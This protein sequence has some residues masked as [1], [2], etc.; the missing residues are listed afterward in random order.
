MEYRRIGLSG[1]KVSTIS[2][3]SW[4]TYGTVTE[5]EAA[6]TC[7][8]RAYDL[9]VNHFDCADAYGDKPGDAEQFLGEALADFPRSSYVLAT[10]CYWPVGPG[11]NDRG[12]SRKHIFESVDN[13]LRRLRTDY[14]DVFY[15]HRYDEE[16]P[17]D[18]TLRAL[19]DLIRQGKVLYAGV[20]EWSATQLAAAAERARRWHL[21]PIIVNQPEY[22]IL[23]RRI[24]EEVLPVCE[25]E[26]IGTIVWSPLAQGLLTGKYRP[27]QSPPEGSRGA[28]PRV[29][30]PMRGWL[31]EE[32]MQVVERLRP[33]A[34]EAG[35]PLA[36]MALAWCLRSPLV[37]SALTGATRPAQVEENVRAAD[38]VLGPDVLQAIDA[39]LA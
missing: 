10:K 19:D 39:A 27:G 9:G 12:L 3:G 17:L 28:H 22:N 29:G 14:I 1:L 36:Q 34:R 15:C 20:S 23:Q 6:R 25:R 35:L 13:S 37:A 30:R 38:V 11:P 2:L 24:E 4:L 32:H 21:H 26:G 8:Q 31:V 7:V 16:T 5:R 18:E 33:I